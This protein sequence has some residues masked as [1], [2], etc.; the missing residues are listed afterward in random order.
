MCV[1]FPDIRIDTL[2]GSANPDCPG[3]KCPPEDRGDQERLDTLWYWKPANN[4]EIA[5]RYQ[6]RLTAASF[7]ASLGQTG[8]AYTPECSMRNDSIIA[9]L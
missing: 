4:E 9:L 6:N 7:P 5:S 1:L 3:V 2:Y 8:I